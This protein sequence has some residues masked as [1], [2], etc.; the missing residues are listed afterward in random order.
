[1]RLLLDIQGA[2]G[3]SRNS[4]IGRY[5][6]ALARALAET[7]GPHE[8][9]VLMN[10]LLGES[11]DALQ[12][13]FA[14]LL[15]LGA[16]HRFTPPDGC[17]AGNDPHHPARLL[18]EQ[19]RAQA[20]LALAPDM[21]HVGSLFEGWNEP[22][23]TTWP[24]ALGGP[25]TV[26][27]LYDLIPLSRPAEYLDGAWR[28]AGLVPWYMRHLAALRDMDGL[29]CISGATMAE[30]AAV[31]GIAAG[32]LRTI[33]SGVAPLFRP[34]G[35]PAPLPG[36]YLLCLGLN[37]TRKNEGRLIQAMA[38]L[39]PRLR[40]GLTLAV[41]GSAPAAHLA[42][43]AARA[44]LPDGTI[45]HL[46]TVPEAMLPALYS[47]AALFVMPSLAE[48]FGLPLAEAMA[49]GAPFCASRAGALPEVAG[50]DDVLFDPLDVADIARVMG[51]I[52]GDAALADELRAYGPMTA[53]QH[54]WP[55]A[56]R[57]AW[58]A[59]EGWSGPPRPARPTLAVTGP[60]PPTRSGIADYTAELLPELAAH[61][62]ITMISE[63]RPDSGPGAGLPWQSPEVFAR[64][65]YDADRV[66]HQLGN[67][68]LH[69]TQHVTLL[70]LR[71]AVT[72]L[73]DV[74]LPEYRQWAAREAGRPL[75]DALYRN[76]GYPGLLA[77][78]SG[79][80]VQV[81]ASL[82]MSAEVLEQSLAVLVHSQAAARLLRD[83]YGQ[84]L[85]SAVEV[86]PLLR[87]L[88]PP[89]DRAGARARL[90]LASDELQI[91]SFGACVPKKLPVRLL[92]AFAAAALP[93]ARLVFAGAV[94][95]GLD[96]VLHGAA[97]AVGLPADALL[98][99]GGLAR[100]H[101]E[102]WLAAA[103]IAVQLRGAHQG[104][105]S[106]AVADAM[107]AELP[108]IA[109][110]RGSL[111]EL[112]PDT[113]LL[114]PDDFTQAAL[115]AALSGLAADPLRRRALGAAAR[116]WVAGALDPAGIALRYRDVIEKAHRS[117][118]LAVLRAAARMT[119]PGQD[120]ARQLARSL[121]ASFPPPRQGRLHVDEAA[122]WDEAGF[123]QL[124][125][126]LRPEPVRRDADGWV[127]AHASL[128]A[129]L[130]L[131]SPAA[132][133]Q[134]VLFQPGDM[135]LTPGSHSAPPGVMVV[136]GWCDLTRLV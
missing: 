101:Y 45:R 21:I 129:R 8:V 112:P 88:P 118:A 124:H 53:A 58:T 10:G 76:Q 113:A 40:N 73:H 69:H 103:D 96:D 97:R 120:V 90:G 117:P 99:T 57:R 5:T 4:G 46:G 109:N 37:D 82:P 91:V 29:L 75:A 31:G 39:P 119:P 121:A 126:D 55:D 102:D 105:T 136:P 17:A 49:C 94:H 81:A 122:G 65:P 54:N 11:A 28:E 50:R 79:N 56:A 62:A 12:A 111:A 14:P 63:A 100:P 67:A 13:E 41:T 33:G 60:L 18:A 132:P 7:R 85:T 38:L 71:P 23:V 51:R 74:A 83:A 72:V 26:A 87:R 61:Y 42:G 86:V 104:E 9:L 93:G 106:A 95:P 70:P 115:V 44:G 135:L 1:M 127:E 59:M 98:L 128:A 89:P 35:G 15:G 2:Q 66:L 123:R 22:L 25:R 30:G 114:L 80:A 34:D 131:A 134:A 20:I 27:T 3:S 78:L 92:E 6:R 108:C 24:A 52:L 48:G 16:I 107:A 133:D 68:A 32:R 130:G 84:T 110:A 43:L 125:G 116:R 77:G 47:G 64:R 19:V 36:R